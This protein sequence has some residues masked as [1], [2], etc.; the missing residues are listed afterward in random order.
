[1]RNERP[2]PY[3]APKEICRKQS[4]EPTWI[5]YLS[6][7][8]HK[9]MRGITPF[10]R[11]HTRQSPCAISV[12][13]RCRHRSLKNLKLAHSHKC[14]FT[15]LISPDL[16]FAKHPKLKLVWMA[17]T[18]EPTLSWRHPMAMKHKQSIATTS[19]RRLFL[20]YY[21]SNIFGNQ[22]RSKSDS[23]PTSQ[24]STLIPCRQSQ[25]EQASVLPS[26]I[27]IPSRQSLLPTSDVLRRLCTR[28]DI[29]RD[30]YSSLLCPGDARIK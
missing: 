17:R 24:P 8:H 30:I 11:S 10:N 6:A 25:Y 15:R 16:E 4:T 20:R 5:S 9:K 19:F 3:R 1:M 26:P 14:E 29:C 22:S 13:K 2:W 7:G 27:P 23:T 21:P 12:K 18:R 28:D